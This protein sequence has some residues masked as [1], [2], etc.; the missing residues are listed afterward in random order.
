MTT[1]VRA[2]V[3]D[4]LLEHDEPSI[5]WLTRTTVLHEDDGSPACVR[6]RGEIRESVRVRALLDGH[7]ELRPDT[8]GKWH[9]AHWVL[10]HLTELGYPSG[11][12]EVQP[13]LDEVLTAWTAPYFRRSQ[14]LIGRS[15]GSVVPVV[16]GRHR[17]HAS[18]QGSAL[19]SAVRLGPQDERVATLAGMLR[20]WQWDDGGWNCDRHTHAISSSAHE[21]WLPMRGLHAYAVDAD[22][23]TAAGAARRAAEVLLARRVVLRRSSDQPGHRDWLRLRYPAYWHYGLLVGLVALDELGLLRDERCAQALDLLEQQRLPSGW[24]SAQGR[25]YRGVGTE[26]GASIDYV[27]WGAAD[28]R[29]PNP[30]V[31]VKALAVLAA[32]GRL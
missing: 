11:Q 16:A 31:T 26:P 23:E 18:L 3:V 4:D 22:D 10:A 7:A 28:R 32:A 27:D 13:L 21:T 6:L 17:V 2:Q 19:L 20:R 29:T 8:Y 24:W 1:A 14:V 25:Y 30:W 9:G 12:A 5:R 15:S